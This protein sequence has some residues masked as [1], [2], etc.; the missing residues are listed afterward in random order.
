[1]AAAPTLEQLPMTSG[2]FRLILR[3]YGDTPE[4]RAAIL[5]GTGVSE[6][7]A[8]DPATG[9]SLF[10]QVRQVEN[11]S[12][13]DGEGWA[14]TAPRLWGPS[15]HGPLGVAALAAPDVAAMVEVVARYGPIRAP[16]HVMTLRLGP[17]WSRIDYAL[18]TPIDERL[19]RPMVEISFMGL[20]ALF[21]AI[22][23]TTPD[24]ASFSFACAE[25]SHGPQARAALGTVAYGASCNSVRFPSSWLPVES[26]FADPVLYAAAIGELRLA[27]EKITAP[28]GLRGRVERLLSTLPAGRLNAEETARMMGVSRRTLVRR[29]AEAGVGYRQ[30]V[31]AELRAR[32]GRLL[33][34]G[35]MNR[36]SVAEALGYADPTSFSRA[37]RRW[38]GPGGARSRTKDQAAV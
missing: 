26:P 10:Q 33:R 19:W 21:A 22:M 2:Y 14:L 12:A 28:V 17:V 3:G 37:C 27:A 4:R 7:A 16:F 11:M 8:R 20:R 25:P 1:M 38:F 9:I 6:E 34:D 32:A 36:A 24:G 13:L 35:G 31:D 23:T 30:L 29:L 18:T 15:A 5:A